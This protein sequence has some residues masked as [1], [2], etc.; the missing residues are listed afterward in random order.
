[1]KIANDLVDA[2]I[3]QELGARIARLRLERNLTQ[4]ELATQAGISKRT[5]ERMEAGGP[6][7][8]AKLVRVCRA[9]G[10]AE[11]FDLLLPEPQP[12][13]VEQLR[14]KG[15]QRQRAVRRG[16]AREPAA[17]WTWG[18]EAGLAGQADKGQADKGQ[19]EK[20]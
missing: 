13:P 11:R 14:L 2:V 1:M 20:P 16:E 17:Q 3:L 9:L 5:L 19:P 8:L 10:F 15:R 6:T 7:E 18:D 12:S 4:T